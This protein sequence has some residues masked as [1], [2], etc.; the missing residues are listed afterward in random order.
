MEDEKPC[1]ICQTIFSIKAKPEKKYCSGKCA[2]EMEYIRKRARYR[3]DP[4]YRARELLRMKQLYRRRVLNK[5]NLHQIV[6]SET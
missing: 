6:E 3:S 4:V 1:V 2:Q 5:N